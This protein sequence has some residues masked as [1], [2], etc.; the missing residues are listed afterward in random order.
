MITLEKLKIFARYD[1]DVDMFGRAGRTGERELFPDSER[2]LVDRLIEDATVLDRNLGS[3][4]RNAEA[5]KRL[6]DNCEDE[7]VIDEIRRLARKGPPKPYLGRRRKFLSGHYS[8]PRSE[9]SLD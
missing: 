1:G 3:E 7:K 5:L 9:L 4:Q 2:H 8:V 6:Q